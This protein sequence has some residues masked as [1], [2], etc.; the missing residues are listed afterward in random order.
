MRSLNHDLGTSQ[1]LNCAI[2]VGAVRLPS[3][4]QSLLFA[5]NGSLTRSGFPPGRYT[6]GI[7]DCRQTSAASRTSPCM[8]VQRLH[9]TT[10][11]LNVVLAHARAVFGPMR[12]DPLRPRARRRWPPV[13]VAQ[14][15]P[16]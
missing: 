8:D 5:A 15:L 16:D 10:G 12:S 3:R 1:L 14:L 9:D 13:A 11:A 7:A 6:T 4:S 2:H